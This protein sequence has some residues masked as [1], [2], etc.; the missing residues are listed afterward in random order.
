MICEMSCERIH[1]HKTKS[2]IPVITVC[3]PAIWFGGY[4]FHKWSTFLYKQT[5][6]SSETYITILFF[7]FSTLWWFNMSWHGAITHI[8]TW[9]PRHA[10]SAQCFLQFAYILSRTPSALAEYPCAGVTTAPWQPGSSLALLV[11]AA[12]VGLN[13]LI[14]TNRLDGLQCS[15]SNKWV[16]RRHIFISGSNTRSHSEMI[17][18]QFTAVRLRC[19]AGEGVWQKTRWKTETNTEEILVGHCHLIGMCHSSSLSGVCVCL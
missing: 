6:D 7:F 17:P 9:H 14:M 13:R 3:S 16:F 19:F 12:A 10:Q 15:G 4:L 8:E 1:A 5:V 11:L 2:M 18:M